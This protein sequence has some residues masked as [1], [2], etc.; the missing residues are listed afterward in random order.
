MIAKPAS[1]VNNRQANR[2]EDKEPFRGKQEIILESPFS[3]SKPLPIAG[4]ERR[5]VGME[6]V[7][8][9]HINLTTKGF[10]PR[11]V[12]GLHKWRVY[13]HRNGVL[14]IGCTYLITKA[15]VNQRP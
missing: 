3:S 1:T 12:M 7:Q 13:A 4:E 6:G 5:L 2:L 10:G 15:V 14:G 11:T 9:R 8:S